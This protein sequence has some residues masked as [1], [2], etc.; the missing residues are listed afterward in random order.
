MRTISDGSV[1]IILSGLQE[2]E[3][4]VYSDDIVL[5]TDT[6]E[7]HKSKLDKLMYR[8]GKFNF[9]TQLDKCILLRLK[10]AYL[11]HIIG[12]N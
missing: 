1:D 7:E 5:F 6:L 3:R 9:K 8:L 4:F 11:A 10:V 2:I 12:E